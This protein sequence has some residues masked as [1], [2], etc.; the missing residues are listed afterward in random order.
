MP[1]AEQVKSLIDA[2]FTRDPERFTTIALQVAA[3]EA[4]QG[5]TA[6]AAEIRGLVDKAKVSHARVVPFRSDLDDLMLQEAP[7]FRFSDLVVDSS[8][9]TRLERVVREFRQQDEFRKPRKHLSSLSC[10]RQ[11]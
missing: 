7:H 5:H 2:H 3:H 10:C 8:I 4:R 11:S 1:T 9:K 6:V